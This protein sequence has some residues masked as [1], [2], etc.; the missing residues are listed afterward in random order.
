MVPFLLSKEFEKAHGLQKTDAR[1]VVVDLSKPF[2]TNSFEIM[3]QTK[4]DLNVP[5]VIRDSLWTDS[6]QDSIIIQ[7]GEFF[8]TDLWNRSS[9][10]VPKPNIP[11]YSVWKFGLGDKKWNNVTSAITMKANFVRAVGGAGVSAPRLNMSFYIGFAYGRCLK[12]GH[13]N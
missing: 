12:S 8:G 7:G 2:N 4:K 5:V 10:F 11:S 6:N 1:T 13:L 9:Y 3:S